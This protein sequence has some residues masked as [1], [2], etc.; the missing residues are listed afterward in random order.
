VQP[1]LTS[2]RLVRVLQVVVNEVPVAREAAGCCV[3]LQ[4]VSGGAR[5]ARE[6]AGCAVALLVCERG[7]RV[8]RGRWAGLC[9]SPCFGC[10]AA[11]LLFSA[12]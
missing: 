10:V 4:V 7:G 12:V 9:M 2:R 11:A 6:L 3:R 5:F 8:A 1:L